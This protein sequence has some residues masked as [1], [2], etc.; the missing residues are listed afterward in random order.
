MA[1][2][3][4]RIPHSVFPN[5]QSRADFGL[6]IAAPGFKIRIPHSQI[7]TQKIPPQ[8]SG[9]ASGQL[10]MANLSTSFLQFAFCPLPRLNPTASKWQVAN[11]KTHHKL[12]CNLLFAPC[13]VSIPPPASGK[14]QISAQVFC[15]LPFA[16]CSV[17]IPP[18]ASG[19]WQM[20][21]LSTS[22]LQFAFCPLLRLNPTANIRLSKWQVASCKWQISASAFLQFAFCPL[23]RLNPTAN[24]RSFPT[25]SSRRSLWP[26]F[27]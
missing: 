26:P 12:F 25:S 19:K 8:T 20:A 17:S 3:K 27:G 14:W 22:F 11:G 7:R 5:P 1:Y 13:P 23:L 6:E 10:Q 18:P 24:I 16:P 4:T 21:N 9:R 2:Q 15:N